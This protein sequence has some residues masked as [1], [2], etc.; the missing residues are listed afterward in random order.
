MRACGIGELMVRAYAERRFAIE[1]WNE[2]EDAM[3]YYD[4]LDE[5]KTD[6]HPKRFTCLYGPTC[7]TQAITHYKSSAYSVEA[8]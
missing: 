5:F 1:S 8:M 2:S 4:E 3:I 7:L 6:V